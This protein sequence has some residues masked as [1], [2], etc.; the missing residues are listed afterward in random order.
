VRAHASW[1]E[2][3]QRL[4]ARLGDQTTSAWFGGSVV[5]RRSDGSVVLAFGR[6]FVRDEVRNRFRDVLDDIFGVPVDLVVDASL[7]VKP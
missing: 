5:K 7:A 6:A 2:E 4:R 1:G 3:S